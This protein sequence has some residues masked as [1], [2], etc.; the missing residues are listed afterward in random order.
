M[1]EG[2][3]RPQLYATS[4]IGT[5]ANIPRDSC[6]TNNRN[7]PVL[8]GPRLV[9][10]GWL[11]SPRHSATDPLTHNLGKPRTGMAVVKN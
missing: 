8:V 5:A 3:L 2:T 6:P 7:V 11:R 9:K 10:Q 4:G 1:L